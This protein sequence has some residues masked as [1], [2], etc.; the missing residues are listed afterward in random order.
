MAVSL[1]R[2]G[3]SPVSCVNN[4]DIRN[5][6]TTGE[7]EQIDVTA[8]GSGGGTEWWRNYAVG[9]LNQTIEIECLSHSASAGTKYGSWECTNI[10]TNEPIDDVVTYTLTFK[11][12][13]T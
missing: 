3:S 5:I 12:A 1:G 7:A 4:D 10:T 9:F 13:S 8:R 2:D 6:T 11:P